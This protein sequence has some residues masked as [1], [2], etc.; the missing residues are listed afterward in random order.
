M[1]MGMEKSAC[2][3]DMEHVGEGKADDSVVMAASTSD[4]AT[5]ALI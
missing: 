5:H 4:V 1:A 2:S 3:A